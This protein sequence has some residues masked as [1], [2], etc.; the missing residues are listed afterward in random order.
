MKKHGLWWWHKA[1]NIVCKRN[2]LNNEIFWSADVLGA[3]R[4][5]DMYCKKPQKYEFIYICAKRYV[6]IFRGGKVNAKDWNAL[7]NRFYERGFQ[8]N[9]IFCLLIKDRYILHS[10]RNLT[11]CDD[12][13]LPKLTDDDFYFSHK[14]QKRFER[15]RQYRANKCSLCE[16]LAHTKQFYK[17]ELNLKM[18]YSKDSF[19]FSNEEINQI[20]QGK[21]KT[22]L[23]KHHY[24]SLKKIIKDAKTSFEMKKEINKFKTTV[25]KNT[26]EST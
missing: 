24:V 16:K 14:L 10:K 20:L 11:F 22:Q 5:A 18:G 4:L 21:T 23:C 1:K 9:S 25:R 6:Q 3:M 8:M 19:L 13:R 26:N 12:F 7:I 2:G 17:S 15:M